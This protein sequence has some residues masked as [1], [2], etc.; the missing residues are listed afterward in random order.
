M[1]TVSGLAKSHGSR[2]LFRDVTFQLSPGRRIALIGGNGV[3]KSTICEIIVGL[4]DPDAGSVSKPND[5]RI[6]YLPQELMEAWTGTVLDE[7]MRGSGEV[8]ALEAELR[9]LET[10]I[11]ESDGPEAEAALEAYGDA[12][13]RF[14][15]MGGYQLEA[16]ARRILGG[17]GFSTADMDRPLTEM[18]GGWQ[19]RAVLARLLLHKPDLLVLDEPTNHLDVDSVAWL[20]QQLATWPGA[21][22]FVSHDR[23]FIDAVAERCIEIA[24]NTATEYI[25]GF[26]E[27]IVAREERLAALEAA[28]GRQ[29][30]EIA[31]VERFIERFRY[32]ATKA[33]Q[34]QS[35]I[36]TLEKL[37][38]IEVPKV[39]DLK[40]RF[41]FPDPPRSSRLV[42]EVDDAALGY[43]GTPIITGVNLVVERGDK[44]ALIG[45]NGAGKT[46]LLKAILG[47]LAP[48]AGEVKLGAN[49]DVASFAQH[50]VD[51]LDMDRTVEQEFRKAVGEQ[52]K[53]RNIRT[54]LGSF[55]FSGEATER[56]VGDL[57]GGERT[58]LA[59]AETMCN[60]VNLLILDEP[61]NHLDLASCDILEDALAAYPGT[62]LLVSHDR[63][64][65]RNTVK[66]VVEVRDGTVTHH[67]DVDDAVLRPGGGKLSQSTTTGGRAPSPASRSS[68]AGGGVNRR[69]RQATKRSQAEARNAKSRDTRE[70]RKRVERLERQATKAEESVRDL[71]VRLA[72]PDVYADKALMNDLINEHETAQSKAARLLREWEDASEELER[73]G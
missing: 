6:G 73:V 56:L 50:Q 67:R 52:P 34:V 31:R 35:R 61:T 44:L 26:A 4:Q 37:D 32:K 23:D 30:A 64:L 3:G 18:S 21:I 59:L 42:I 13:S 46:T 36:K 66:E 60:P 17:L 33:R 51:S 24:W 16:D 5:H 62:V 11:G 54:V 49:V 43:D 72:D 71:E 47:D 70:L 45:P 48:I 69:D 39:E 8:L 15:A 2:T 55:G 27:F 38:R 57:S 12:Q 65:V 7:V 29:A 63:Y 22:L 20:E 19:M 28:A 53:N 41:A 9:R 58:R 40:L 25:G 14:E 1:L 10:V 68:N